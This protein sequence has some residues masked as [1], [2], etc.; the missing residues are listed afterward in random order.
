MVVKGAPGAA[1]VKAMQDV[2]DALP[3][4]VHQVLRAANVTP[5]ACK[6]L[7]GAYKELKGV[8]PRGWPA[9][10]TW[11]NAD[12]ACYGGDK[13]TVAARYRDEWNGNQWADSNR[14]AHVMRHEIGHAYDQ[15][16]GFPSRSQSFRDAYAADVAAADL[17][18][19]AS[20]I[21]SYFLQP[22]D[23]GPS[24]AFA[25]LVSRAVG[26]GRNENM[27]TALRW[28]Q[29]MLGVGGTKP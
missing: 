10:T 13:P 12:G 15:A 21:D 8:T 26:G 29:A 6:T 25:Q 14:S 17:G 16:A 24:E 2:V 3:P 7:T 27:P 20:K 23:A 9:G 11:D 19:G 18:G 1:F 5:V 22:G 28:V 4:V